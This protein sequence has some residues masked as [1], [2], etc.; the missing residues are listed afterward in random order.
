MGRKKY[1]YRI[2]IFFFCFMV[3]CFPMCAFASEVDEPVPNGVKT[4]GQLFVDGFVL[5]E[6]YSVNVHIDTE[7]CF[8]FI[9][10][11]AV[12]YR[13][14]HTYKEDGPIFL[15]PDH[16][17]NT[18]IEW[19]GGTSSLFSLTHLSLSSPSATYIYCVATLE[20]G[21]EIASKRVTLVPFVADKDFSE[22]IL[23]STSLTVSF[24]LGWMN[25]FLQFILANPALLV[26]F[27]FLL[28]GSGIA[29]L[30]RLWKS[31]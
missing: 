19:S 16:G 21:S 15:F 12:S 3:M 1:R 13:W 2:G 31:S 8:S 24:I 7:Y 26:M 17:V 30:I 10:Q 11:G 14:Y 22:G 5:V 9:V 4:G 6:P 27:L 28:A 29:F 25:M 18:S 20:D 23:P